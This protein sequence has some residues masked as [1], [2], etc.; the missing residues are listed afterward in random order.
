MKSKIEGEKKKFDEAID[1]FLKEI[2]MS[3]EK[4]KEIVYSKLNNYHSNLTSFYD[5]YR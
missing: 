4:V 5:K 3:M 1:N 2:I